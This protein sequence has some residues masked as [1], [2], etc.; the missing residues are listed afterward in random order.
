[1]E[2]AVEGGASP[3]ARRL[4]RPDPVIVVCLVLL[5]G[6]TVIAVLAA[7]GEPV[8][9]RAAAAPA[10]VPQGPGGKVHA[11]PDFTRGGLVDR[12]LQ[13]R[14]PPRAQLDPLIRRAMAPL[15]DDAQQR[16]LMRYVR[17]PGQPTPPDTP[18]TY[19]YRYAG[20]SDL[21]DAAVPAEP[22]LA[23]A[24]AAADLGG[25]L[26]LAFA[27]ER[28]TG[29]GAQVAFALLDRA[30]GGGA[31][32]PQ[33]NLAL[34]VAA[35]YGSQGAAT[36]ELGRAGRACPDDP[37][38]LWLRG[39]W[40]SVA[41]FDGVL[42]EGVVPASAAPATFRRLQRRFP[43]S[44]AGW[45]GI[46]D[47]EVRL[48]YVAD[49]EKQS[50]TARRH[51]ERA[52]ASY[53]RARRLDRDPRLGAGEARALA[54]LG[55]YA[56]AARLQGATA[57]TTGRRGVVQAWSTEL[58]ER[59]H[60]WADA[61]ASADALAARRR[62]APGTGLLMTSPDPLTFLA[63][64]D[65][66]APISEQVGLTRDFQV[67]I[68][69]AGA[70][71][72]VLP[73]TAVEDISFIPSFREHPGVTGYD[74]WCPAWSGLRDL[75]LAG[76][77]DEA[78]AASPPLPPTCGIGHT[79]MLAAV[80]RAEAG[81]ARGALAALPDAPRRERIDRLYEARQNLWRFAG[82]H[83][84]AAAIVAE[85]ARL[86]PANP[87]PADRAG[88]V[89]FLSGR[90]EDAVLAFGREVRLRRAAT[91][92]WSA[93]EAL[94]LVKR[95][96]AFARIK[97]DREALEAFASGDEVALRSLATH[98]SA[99]AA[100]DAAYYARAQA[101]DLLLRA[102]R[103]ED[104]AEQYTAARE[105]QPG[106]GGGRVNRIEVLDSNQSIVETY[107][108]HSDQG[109]PLARRA[110]RADPLNP[111]FL[112]NE[113]FALSKAG[114]TREAAGAYRRAVG[115]DPS[116]YPAWN[117]L[118]VSLSRLGQRD[119]AA[120]A[121][122]RAVG[123]RRSYAEGWFNL[124]V[125]L[126][127][128]GIANAAAAQ[129]AFAQAFRHDGALR[130]REHELIAD[131]RL[132]VTT[133][134]L[135]K[136]LPPK[137]DFAAS[138]KEAPVAATGLAVLLLLG[139]QLGR[140][141]AGRGLA[142]GTARWLAA[143]R[144]LLS[145]LPRAAASFSPSALAVLVTLAVF[146]V[147]A[148]RGNEGSL[149][150][151]GAFGVGLLVLVVLV[152]RARVLAARRAGVRLRQRSWRPA[153]LVG[154]ASAFVGIPWAPMPVAEP[155]APAP[156]VHRAGPIAAALCGLA[157]LALGMLLDVPL[158]RSL[159]VAAVVL[160]ASML[161]PVDPLDGARMNGGSAAVTAGLALAGTAGLAL[162]GL[163]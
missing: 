153:L 55:E 54:G 69:P 109:L 91:S 8:D 84:R 118:G 21:V 72:A 144:A 62:E 45:S 4:G 46:G 104:A 73:S 6:F 163:E 20:I 136:P 89:A 53:R 51:F 42:G 47:V 129:G 126:E 99:D 64:E 67:D 148:I 94:A 9:P 125:T 146:L 150:A 106:S 18:P 132:Y 88:E 52:L 107:L 48:A 23:Q 37:T 50:F 141:V 108:G 82:D 19:P 59:A 137:W 140:S 116:L 76:R 11:V 38:A 27:A 75:V 41:A 93:G 44:S 31:C 13:G 103:Y 149:T 122:R 39:H 61:V 155:S 92:G 12:E 117:A 2:P 83:T 22:S 135:S 113:G 28:N 102:H 154:V 161:T 152:M 7:K 58:L 33:L 25:V 97:R 78:L 29:G 157:L 16:R 114:R 14:P 68:R 77:P 147:P 17:G 70:P 143:A 30:R 86:R 119:E 138:Q 112:E 65:A 124:G 98:P 32:R 162:L 159:G 1:M 57:A 134:D 85:W 15:F 151:V 131:D 35:S 5:L 80:I 133:L 121:F 127:H 26:M 34:L 63:N 81:D 120:D 10:A 56:A 40:E 95:G 115:S 87:L 24:D 74:R 130:E 156:H 101:G 111:L 160:A 145:K 100:R 79:R 3:R 36:S 158:A 123:V 139:L 60:R 49:A 142:G 71:A 105:V 128:Q 43:R 66:T 110:V 90:F 96:L